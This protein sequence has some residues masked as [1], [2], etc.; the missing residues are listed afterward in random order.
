MY[1]YHGNR[2]YYL[3]RIFLNDKDL[4]ELVYSNGLTD[5]KYELFSYTL[6]NDLYEIIEE[7]LLD[8]E[9]SATEFYDAECESY[10][11]NHNHVSRILN[12]IQT[13]IYDSYGKTY[14]WYYPT[15]EDLY[16]GILKS[17]LYGSIK[18]FF[19]E[20]RSKYL[21]QYDWYL[22]NQNEKRKDIMEM[23]FREFDKLTNV[24]D[25]LK[26]YQDADDIPFEFAIFLQEITGF[27]MNNY[28]DIF[29]DLQLRSLT[30]HLV[31]VW[32]EK[33][34]LFSIEL[35]FACM[36]IDCSVQELWFDRRLYFNP[37]GFNDYTKVQ[38]KSSF[39]YYL[40]P[41]KPHTTSYG[42]SSESID[43]ANYTNPRSSRIWSREIKTSLDVDDTL[44]K[45][46]GFKEGADITYTFFKS[47]YLLINFS[48]V[49]QSKTVSKEELNVYKELIAYILPAFIRVYYGNEYESTYG[50]EQWDIFKWYSAADNGANTYGTYKITDINGDVR[51]AEIFDLFDT[52]ANGD[53]YLTRSG[54]DFV[55]GTGTWADDGFES[56]SVD[57]TDENWGSY[58]V[59]DDLKFL[60][61]ITGKF[62]NSEHSYE[63]ISGENITTDNA[64]LRDDN[65][66]GVLEFALD[67]HKIAHYYFKVNNSRE[68]IYPSSG[69]ESQIP[70]Q[71]TFNTNYTNDY[72]NLFE[73][74][75]WNIDIDAYN[76][77]YDGERWNGDIQYEYSRYTNPL[78]YVETTLTQE[79]GELTITLI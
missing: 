73:S 22:I 61:L 41:L 54:P 7:Y 9:L 58:I 45:L 24:A 60:D 18:H 37:D 21:P 66:E 48:Y 15:N 74:S 35:F 30:K 49:G 38:N 17:V 44:S 62:Y 53:K 76:D 77:L 12:A 2:H 32:R 23:L 4:Q 47:N 71:D 19:Y 51:P 79:G 52:N 16:V 70:C 10:K 31:E 1:F 63:L 56:F 78:E 34:S 5:N 11:N 14:P 3:T 59:V 36:G 20:N 13:A 69:I 50:N 8:T 42:F 46:L 40:T 67:G 25:A 33:G 29:T 28:G 64:M 68:E 27:T 75:R 39:G 43:Y 6:A 26:Y 57:F 55:S 72:L 65:V